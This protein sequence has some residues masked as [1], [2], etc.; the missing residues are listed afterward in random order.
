MIKRISMITALLMSGAAN[1]A[2]AEVS[3]ITSKQY[4]TDYAKGFIS[5]M[6]SSTVA[7]FKKKHG[8]ELL[9]YTTDFCNKGENELKF[10]IITSGA[11]SEL[12]KHCS[13]EGYNSTSGSYQ[14]VLTCI[15]KKLAK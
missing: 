11:D 12:V 13:N 8:Y 10:K 1:M 2:M 6:D 3:A 15:E 4:C 9:K 7:A 14:P 5:R